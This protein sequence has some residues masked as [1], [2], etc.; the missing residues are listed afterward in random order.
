[1]N[2]VRADVRTDA[3]RKFETEREDAREGSRVVL[4][5]EFQNM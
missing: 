3:E 1:V 2:R 4:F 5:E